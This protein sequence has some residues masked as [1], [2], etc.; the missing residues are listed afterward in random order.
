MNLFFLGASG[1][2]GRH[3]LARARA[4]GHAAWGTRTR[5][6][7][8]DL[9]PFDLRR[10]RLAPILERLP[11]DPNQPSFGILCA[12][13]R[14]IDQCRQDPA[15]SRAVNCTGTIA[16]LTDFARADF[17]PVFLST[18]YVFS[19]ATGN[20]TEADPP[21]PVCEYGR[22]KLEVEQWLTT[23]HPQALILRLDKIV[24][25]ARAE[26][27]LFSEW[28][29]WLAAGR[30]LVCI[31]NQTFSPTDVEDIGC[32]MLLAC[33]RRLAGIWHTA[34]PEPFTRAGLARQFC[35]QMG[36]PANVIE[37]PLSAFDFAD[38][39][40]LNTRLDA[41]RFIRATGQRYTPMAATIAAFRQSPARQPPG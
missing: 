13:I 37:K 23:H 38:P 6:A 36:H 24:G 27:H 40:P 7:A 21:A 10:D 17:T 8:D 1:F 34:N 19:G 16:A 29:T 3:A 20:Y 31:A 11:R 4:A 15:A 30:P 9:I 28:Q 12:S 33:E 39:R 22:Q 35:A 5:P 26:A 18:S 14:Q 41:A 32:S 2:V 25:A